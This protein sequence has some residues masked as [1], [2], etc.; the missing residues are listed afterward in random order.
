MLCC[1]PQ[2]CW[3]AEGGFQFCLSEV[4]PSLP[5]SLLE[6]GDAED[7]HEESQPEIELRREQHAWVSDKERGSAGIQVAHPRLPRGDYSMVMLSGV[8]MT[9]GGRKKVTARLTANSDTAVSSISAETGK[10]VQAQAA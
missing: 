3:E 9:I 8:M 10:A 5:P 4:L 1:T 6:H 2:R 7:P